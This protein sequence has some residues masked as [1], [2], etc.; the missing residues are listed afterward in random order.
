[1]HGDTC[2]KLVAHLGLLA[3]SAV[4]MATSGCGGGGDL[5]VDS[6][7]GVPTA[8][9]AANTAAMVQDL[10][11]N[12]PLIFVDRQKG[13]GYTYRLQDQ[14]YDER[15]L[16]GLL[17]A[18]VSSDSDMEVCIVPSGVLT[19]DEIGLVEAKLR[20]TGVRRVRLAS[21]N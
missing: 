14:Q 19:R 15:E 3:A 16:L 10:G 4:L 5:R 18:I 2:R 7:S 21:M 11:T 8:S 13:G 12:V 6:A 9:E 20:E 17:R 1:M